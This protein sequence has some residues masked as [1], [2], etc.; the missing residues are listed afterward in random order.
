MHFFNIVNSY[1]E[2][3]YKNNKNSELDF[4]NKI[5]DETNRKSFIILL[6]KLI[7]TKIINENFRDKFSNTLLEQ[8]DK[9]V[10]IYNWFIIN[11]INDKEKILI[12]EKIKKLLLNNREKILLSS[13]IENNEISCKNFIIDSNEEEKEDNNTF[14]I[15]ITN[16]FDEYV[17][18]KDEK[19]EIVE[20][21]KESSLDFDSKNLLCENLLKY[22]FSTF[23][24]DI[25]WHKLINIIINKKLIFKSNLSKA[26]KKHYLQKDQDKNKV[27]EL[28]ILFKQ[29]NITKHIE[30]IFK[31]YKIKINNKY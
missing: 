16:L 3:I 21:L 12:K 5:K 13:L 10:D 26:L 11:N 29:N 25:N 4:F 14:I 24:S 1:I 6:E 2:Y 27:K 30:S 28:L 22:Y 17:Y 7:F 19:N 18:L 23:D 8:N 15:E 9:I 31:K 20:Y